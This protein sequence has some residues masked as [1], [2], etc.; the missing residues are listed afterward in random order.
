MSIALITLTFIGLLMM[1]FRFGL[2][3]GQAADQ[4]AGSQSAADA[5][6]LAAARQIRDELPYWVINR[7]K[8]I[9]D[10]DLRGLFNDLESGLGA[11]AAAN[12]AEL[13]GAQIVTYTYDHVNDRIDVTVESN[14]RTSQSTNEPSY[15]TASAELGLQ[16]GD[17]KQLDEA[18]A[19][20]DD[21]EL[22]A[23]K[24][25]QEPPAD[26]DEQDPA[27]DEKPEIG[28]EL[29]CGGIV[30]NFT[31]GG[32]GGVRLDTDPDDVKNQFRIRLA[33]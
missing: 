28:T 23:D 1:I 4:K 3:L 7:A 2:P 5:A 10:G 18:P 17:C 6:A 21:Q 33:E 29:R 30:L 32:E 20:K 22:P 8:S 31:L 9:V 13:N 24:D 27:D 25:E 16:L 26:K 12:F 11:D 19:E 15:S 14:A